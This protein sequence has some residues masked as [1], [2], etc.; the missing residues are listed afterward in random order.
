MALVNTHGH[1]DHISGNAE[2]KARCN[3]PLYIHALDRPMLTDATRNL[4]AFTG[5]P[6]LSPDADQTLA[7]GDTLTIGAETL[8]VLHTPGHTPGSVSFYQSGLLIAGDTLFCGGV[9]RTDLPGGSEADL[10]TSIRTKLYSLP[11]D[12]TVYSGHGPSTTIGEEKRTN[13]FVRA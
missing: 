1:L 6:V 3:V 2:V 13:P 7:D 9:G 12:T 4:S 8:T 11:D 10:L 5:E